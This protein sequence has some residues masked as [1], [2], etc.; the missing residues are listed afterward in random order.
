[1]VKAV[2]IER[3]G[4]PEV[5]QLVDM[6]LPPPGP[7]EVRLRHTAIGFNFGEIYF[8]TG[9]YPATLPSGL[10]TEAVG[11]IETLGEG[12][13]G[14]APGDRALYAGA[15][16]GVYLQGA[17]AEAS[18]ADTGALLKLPNAIDDWA[19][20][21]IMKALTVE[22]LVRRTWAV[23]PG[24]TVLAHAAAGAT[25]AM[26][27]QWARHLG[28]TVIGVVGSQA[29]VAE[30]AANGCH[31]VLVLD[32]AT[33]AERVR[34]LTGGRGV[35]VVYDSVGK[36]TWTASLDCL[37]PRGLMVSYGNSSG[38][39]GDVALGVLAAKG[40]LYVTRPALSTYMTEP[41]ERAEAI[42]AVLAVM[43]SGAVRPPHGREYRLAD[44]VQLHRDAEARLLT[45]TTII[46][47]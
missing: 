32:A 36:D 33:L 5:M 23:K 24:D 38:A 35:D 11:V 29:K 1:M 18:N 25:G 12:V 40:S 17:Y 46:R 19:A 34:A 47:P 30:A 44:V 16:K 43:T 39:V 14:F 28:A 21:S 37:R 42:A 3:T 27:A 7:G 41:A 13:D 31:D 4:G 2:R 45:G 20:T 15:L 8:R 22:Y 6:E 9:L 10:G 26:L